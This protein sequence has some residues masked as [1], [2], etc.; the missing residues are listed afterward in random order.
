MLKS[1]IVPD[2]VI[3]VHFYDGITSLLINK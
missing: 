1:N 2:H 3:V